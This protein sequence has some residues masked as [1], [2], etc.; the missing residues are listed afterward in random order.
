MS[1]R[2]VMVRPSIGDPGTPRKNKDTKAADTEKKW[3]RGAEDE[4]RVKFLA[5]RGRQ[6]AICE[7][8]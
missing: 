4:L 1:D 5:P 7:G 3:I 6:R 8:R 2:E